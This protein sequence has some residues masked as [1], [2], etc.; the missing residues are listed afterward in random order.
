ME[1]RLGPVAEIRGQRRRGD[2]LVPE[3]HGGSERVDVLGPLRSES[4]VARALGDALGRELQLVSVPRDSWADELAAVGF[5]PHIA[6]S[7]AEL[8]GAADDGL[9]DPRGDRTIQ[10]TTPI[11]I[12]IAGLLAAT[13]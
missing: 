1:R 13:R 7:L 11:E 10:V 6:E 2:V 12:T 3:P 5:P 9:L 8:Y 4:D